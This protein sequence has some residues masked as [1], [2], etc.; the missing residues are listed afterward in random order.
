M[1]NLKQN[2]AKLKP[3]RHAAAPAQPAE[4]TIKFDLFVH[5]EVEAQLRPF[6]T[7]LKK[8]GLQ[9]WKTFVS[10]PTK[11]VDTQLL[12]YVVIVP[13]AVLTGES[14]QPAAT[15]VV[16]PFFAWLNRAEVL[17]AQN[18][19]ILLI[20]YKKR[21]VKNLPQLPALAN[22]LFIDEST[23]SVFTLFH[24]LL[25]RELQALLVKKELAT[26]K[27]RRS[28]AAKQQK[29]NAVPAVVKAE[30]ELISKEILNIGLSISKER[31]TVKILEEILHNSMRI[32]HADAG[33]I[34][35]R[36]M[37]KD[38]R[39]TDKNMLTFYISKNISRELHFSRFSMPISE[40]SL[41]GYTVITGETLNIKDAYLISK[42][43]SYSFNREFDK[44][45]N[46]RT[47]SMLVVPMINQKAET[48][49]IIQLINKKSSYNKIIDYASFKE[50]AVQS[51]NEDD[52][53]SLT[54]LA[55]LATVSL[56]NAILYHEIDNL[57]HS[58][59][60]ASVSAVEQRDPATSGHS[61]R[62][63]KF[64]TLLAESCNKAGGIFD[65]WFFNKTQL[66]EL[67]YASL[68]HDFGKIGVREPVLLKSHKME[69]QNFVS[70]LRKFDILALNIQLESYREMVEKFREGSSSGMPMIE[71]EQDISMIKAKQQKKLTEIKEHRRTIER[72]N[73][74]VPLTDEVKR[75]IEDCSYMDVDGMFFKEKLVTG[76]EEMLLSIPYG[77][78]SQTERL[79]I[80]SHVSHTFEFLKK[81]PWTDELRHIPEIAHFHHEKMDGSGYPIGIKGDAIPNQTKIMTI[82]DI[83]DALTSADRPYKKSMEVTKA[84][85]ILKSES[86]TG[87]LHNDLLELF[88]RNKHIR[89]A[90]RVPK[91]SQLEV[92]L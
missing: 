70:L 76:R 16:P 58:F 15:S 43:K 86:K 20:P 23:L 34:A 83:Y 25:L 74:G 40:K 56:Q 46:F 87:K 42:S 84:I 62:V 45:T 1:K 73:E 69:E 59:V 49:G 41:G 78:L 55:S 33:S 75:I 91:I 72:C 44:K 5:R 12:P 4:T 37:D 54:A 77:T 79:E 14:L 6:R 52:A 92:I 65:D 57:F 8:L 90:V 26:L 60:E 38:L 11:Q 17:H 19:P 35:I 51:F 82:C 27:K 81:I 29:S 39:K 67:E 71:L 47:K 88:I 80:Q 63:S 28:S 85:D 9:K 68:L 89:E 53:V 3:S 61:F 22:C 7:Q 30:E 24:Q 10:I 31:D 32:T 66:R 2:T 64:S 48:I 18:P 13:P 50:S 36:G 21:Q